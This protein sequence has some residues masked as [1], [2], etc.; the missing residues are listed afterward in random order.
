ML[1]N[2]QFRVKAFQARKISGESEGN[3]GESGTRCVD[4]IYI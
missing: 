4:K 2:N 1:M 3:R